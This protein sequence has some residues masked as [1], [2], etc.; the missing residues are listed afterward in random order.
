ME[1]DYERTYYRIED[2]HA[3]SRGRR[4]AVLQLLASLRVAKGSHILEVGCGSGMLLQAMRD[5]GYSNLTGVDNS[6]AALRAAATRGLGD[7]ITTQDAAATSFADESFDV[8]V[9]SDVLEH[10]LN[11]GQALAEWRRVLKPGGHLLLFVPAFD[12]LWS[13]HDL[14]NRH[15]RRYSRS[16]LQSVTTASGFDVL[17]IGYWNVGLFLPI[18]LMRMLMRMQIRGKALEKQGDFLELP[19][20]VNESI[21]ALFGVENALLRLGVNFP[22]GVSVFALLQRRA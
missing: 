15:F 2:R 13:A 10:L 18:L 4:D 14:A 17:R 8:V 19:G 3:W 20:P 12:F 5:A 9:A 21:A 11:E 1:P 22:L 16:Q 6:E 7:I